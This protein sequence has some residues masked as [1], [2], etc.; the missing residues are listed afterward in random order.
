VALGRLIRALGEVGRACVALVRAVL[1]ITQLRKVEAR[2]WE[3]RPGDII[4]LAGAGWLD[5]RSA[6]RIAAARGRGLRYAALIHDIIPLRRPEWCDRGHIRNFRRWI[7]DVLPSSDHL[8]AISR[9]TAAELSAFARE[10]R[11]AMPAAPAVVRMGCG[12]SHAAPLADRPPHLPPAGSYVL[13]VST[14]EAR[15]NHI[16][17]VRVWQRLLA[18]R[19]PHRVPQLVFVGREGPQVAPLMDLLR[20]TG[21]LGGHVLHMAN[22]SD[23]DLVAL[24]AGCLFTLYPSLYEGW[25]LPITESLFFGKPCV[26]ANISSLPEAGGTLCRYLDPTDLLDGARVV[27]EILD[28]PAGLAAWQAR[29]AESFWPSS[30]DD[31]ARGVIAELGGKPNR[32]TR[33]AA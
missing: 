22:A 4:F 6:A 23:T 5:Q 25:G 28:D 26:A 31:M 19:G 20:Q 29:I 8:L 16:Y 14:L 10:Q 17:A 3:P 7:S 33:A 12:F 15:K 13:F 21:H 18:E 30:W 24:Y 11:I 32:A 2:P 1:G 9:A 27:S